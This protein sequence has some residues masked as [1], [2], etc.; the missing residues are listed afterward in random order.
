MNHKY[1]TQYLQAANAEEDA[2]ARIASDVASLTPT[3]RST[4]LMREFAPIVAKFYKVTVEKSRE[5]WPKYE[6]DNA[7]TAK[8]R[9]TRLVY[10]L[11]Q[12]GMEFAGSRASV[13][14]RGKTQAQ[15][16]YD[17]AVAMLA[18]LPDKLAQKAY[19]ES[20]SVRQGV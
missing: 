3:Q 14:K 15:K 17:R 6:G 16:D 12:L 10:A 2:I 11:R 7:N 9:T 18:K 5:G 1:I 19:H 4:W 20:R 13:G 8:V